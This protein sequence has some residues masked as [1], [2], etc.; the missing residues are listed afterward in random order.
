MLP[1]EQRL[2][3]GHPARA[4]GHDG[5]VP[6]HELVPVERV[7]EVGLELEPRHGLVAHGVVEDHVR[8]APVGLGAIER[9]VRVAEHVGGAG[10]ARRAQRDADARG[11]EDLLAL[12][13]ERLRELLTDPLG[14]EGGIA[15]V[16]EPGQQDG[17]FVSAEPRDG[18]G[19][20]PRVP[21]VG[22]LEPTD[23]VARSE[24]RFQPMR[25]LHE[26][27]ITGVMPETVVDV[28]EMIQIQEQQ[29]EAEPRM[30]LA[31]LDQP[32]EPVH[33][34]HAI[35]KPGQRIGHLAAG[36]VGQRPGHPGR[37]AAFV[38]DD[39]A[40]GEHPAILSLLVPHAMLA[41][42]AAR[43]PGAMLLDLGPDPLD[44]VLVHAGEP[45]VERAAGRFAAEPEQFVPAMR[46]EDRAG[47]DLPVPEAIVAPA[48]RQGISLF[49]LGERALGL[50]PRELGADS[51]QRDGEVDRLGDVVVRAEIEGLDDVLRVRLRGHH[52]DGQLDWRVGDTQRAQQLDAAHGRHLDV[53]QDQIDALLSQEVE[54]LG[55]RRGNLDEV[56][57]APEASGEQVAVVLFVVDHEQSG[58]E[59]HAAPRRADSRGGSPAGGGLDS[60]APGWR[61]HNRSIASRRR[62]ALTGLDSTPAAPS[63]TACARSSTT[64]TMTTG[65]AATAG[66]ALRARSTS[67]PSPSGSRMSSRIRS[68]RT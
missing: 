32:A 50:L 43:S 37:P 1:P 65:M 36:D 11:G 42:E 47:V 39:H 28:L 31:V 44:I 7:A 49:A 61:R 25:G 63:A 21:R 15:I 53:E 27:L 68:G 62:S 6:Q 29:R 24:A 46:V 30:P 12:E 16:L 48:E 35:R 40:A 58:A 64:L 52:D 33:E 17:E 60:T 5:L 9:G 41:L 55:A 34:Q 67:H 66:F 14:D 57:L 22:R 59:H 56:P 51:S 20:D 19:A 4:N 54:R 23:R 2:D 18:A 26:Q 38:P 3:A 45:D 8:G 10:V 13:R